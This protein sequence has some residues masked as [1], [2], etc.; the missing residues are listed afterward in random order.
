MP[1]LGSAVLPFLS[2]SKQGAE[3]F[4]LLPCISFSSFRAANLSA[5]FYTSL[6]YLGSY[7]AEDWLLLSGHFGTQQRPVWGRW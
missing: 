6:G 5:S 3:M 7:A 1:A 2:L 4:S